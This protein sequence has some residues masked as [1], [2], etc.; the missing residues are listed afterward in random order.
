MMA[1]DRAALWHRCS[2][3]RE[4]YYLRRTTI[5]DFRVLIS[6]QM[7]RMSRLGSKWGLGA[8]KSF[9]HFCAEQNSSCA[10]LGA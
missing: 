3:S 6:F 1:T 9:F 8:D 4:H 5:L 10:S 2:S 7:S